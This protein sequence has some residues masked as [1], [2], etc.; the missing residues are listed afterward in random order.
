MLKEILRNAWQWRSSVCFIVFALMLEL[1][2]LSGLPYSFR[3]IVDDGILGGDHALLVRI[4]LLLT[5]GAAVFTV[6]GVFRDRSL[7]RL[8]ARMLC[9]QYDL[10][11][12]SVQ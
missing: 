2:F 3:F 7:S 12:N 8:I 9:Q 6:I 11:A 5:L 4:F 1:A 10:R